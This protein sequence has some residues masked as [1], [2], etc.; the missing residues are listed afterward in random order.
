MK[1]KRIS[2]EEYYLG[3][4]R[5]VSQRSTCFR[6]SIGALIVRDDQIISTGYVGAPRKTKDSF[7]HGV[8]LRDKLNIPH[9]QRYELCRSVHAEQNAIINA[10]RAGVSLLGGDMYIFGSDFKNKKPIDAFPCFICKKMIINAGL[11]RVIC[12]TADGGFRIFEV[13]EWVKDWRKEDIID[14]K[15]QYG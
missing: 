15:H 3:I 8:C 6:R 2:K 1:P 11:K 10:A 5:E 14:D 13:E 7:Q 9:G 12:S 4:A